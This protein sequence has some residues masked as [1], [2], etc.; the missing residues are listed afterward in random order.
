M[1]TEILYV[2]LFFLGGG[3]GI[4][5][6]VLAWRLKNEVFFILSVIVCGLMIIYIAYNFLDIISMVKFSPVMFL[7]HLVFIG[8]PIFFIVKYFQD[9]NKHGGDHSDIDDD[10]N[11]G[12]VTDQYLD[13]IIN[14]ADEDLDFGEGIDLR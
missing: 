1:F 13:E 10:Q 5:F 7:L 14:S 3:A 4:L 11:S 12:A 8:L 6:S 2:M 9:K